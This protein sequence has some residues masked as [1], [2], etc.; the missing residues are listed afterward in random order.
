MLPKP[1]VMKYY[2]YLLLAAM[3]VSTASATEITGI[4]SNVRNGEPI[5]GV[6]V[7]VQNTPMKAVTNE[8][9]KYTMNLSDKDANEGILIFSFKG[10]KIAQRAIAAKSDLNV[11]V[12]LESA[13]PPHAETMSGFR[14]GDWN[15]NFGGNV[16]AHYIY[17]SADNSGNVVQGSA[18]LATG[19]N[20]VHSVQSGLLP[21]C[22]AFS[23][24]TVT[25]DSFTIAATIGLF[26][27]TVSNAG[28]AYSDLDLRQT[29]LTVS[30]PTMGTFTFGRNFGLFG[31]DAIINDIS[32]IGA[33]ATALSVNPLNTTLGGIGYG[34]VYCDRLSQINYTTPD[35]SGFD[36]TIGIFNPL[37]VSSLGISNSYGLGV[38]GGAESGS[39]RPGIHGKVKYTAGGFYGSASFINQAVRIGTNDLSSTGFDVYAKY[40]VSGFGIAGYY[41]NGNGLGTTALLYD[42]FDKTGTGLARTSSGYYAQASYTFGST[43][44]GVN[45]GVS[46]LDKTANDANTM[47]KQHQRV[48]LGLYQPL[49]GPLNLVV[50]F[51]NMQATNHA[52][53]A[54]SNN[55]LNVGVF[56]GF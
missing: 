38:A 42:A 2:F 21:T 4:V 3:T 44:V 24:S 30:K 40:S 35:M 55:A 14:K 23:A 19:A 49:T 1:I 8:Y 51:T 53:A 11:A 29:F 9:G 17:T 45:Y 33:G 56:L 31:F 7:Q 13:A 54:I 5:F 41:Y 6:G 27:G 22:L 10:K 46:T 16:N 18:L 15:M 34:Y 32:L 47:L 50:E 28:L 25:K 39:S 43:K 48:T 26:A 12:A 37:N 36:A 52:G 20:G